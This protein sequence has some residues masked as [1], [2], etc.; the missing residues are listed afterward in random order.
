MVKLAPRNTYPL[1][2]CTFF[3]TIPTPVTAVAQSSSLE[4]HLTSDTA[5]TYAYCCCH[6][7]CVYAH[8]HTHLEVTASTKIVDRASELRYLQKQAAM[9]NLHLCGWWTHHNA[10]ATEVPC[11]KCFRCVFMW[12]QFHCCHPCV[13]VT[14]LARPSSSSGCVCTN[15]TSR[16]C[17]HQQEEESVP[18]QGVKRDHY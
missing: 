11:C 1:E 16:N 7:S 2:L 5:A 3:A 12:R 17:L 9:C 15:C 6:C 13:Q 8:T 4:S 10:L 14:G 18:Y